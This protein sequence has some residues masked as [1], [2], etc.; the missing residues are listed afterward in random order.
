MTFV[1]GGV[2]HSGPQQSSKVA[3]E[4]GAIIISVFNVNTEQL[5]SLLQVT[6]LRGFPD[7]TS[8]EELTCRCT[9]DLRGSDSIPG[10]EISRRRTWQ[11]T[12]VLLPGESHG[13]RS[14]VGNS[15]WDPKE[16]DTD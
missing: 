10:G 1:T 11:P 5:Q 15:P 13:Q 3:C 6:D 8:D 9:R 4:I 2:P 14:L 12:P 7:G 16:S